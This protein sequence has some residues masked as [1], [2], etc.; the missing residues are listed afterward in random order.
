MIGTT[1]DDP[2]HVVQGPS[3]NEMR[4]PLVRRELKKASVWI[5]LVCAVA[6]IVLLI[7]P[8]L[9][10]FAGVVFAAMLDGGVRLLGRVLK[11]GRGW[12]LLIV[13]V[14]VIAFLSATF[15]LTGVEVV[16]QVTQ[17]QDTLIGQFNRVTAWLSQMGIMPGRSDLKS[18]CS[19]RWAR[20]GG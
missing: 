11:I 8:L 14:G 12:R 9:I 16:Q 4:D 15:Y 6:L 1:G 5:G 19:R 3:P 17:L 7:Q 10:I 18:C 20:S 13:V 2:I